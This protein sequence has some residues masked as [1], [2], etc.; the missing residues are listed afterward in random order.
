MARAHL[1]ARRTTISSTPLT[2]LSHGMRTGPPVWSTTTVFGLAVATAVDQ[3]VAVR[4]R[5]SSVRAG[6]RTRPRG[7]SRRRSPRRPPPP[8]LAACAEVAR[9]CCRSTVPPSCAARAVIAVQRRLRRARNR[10][11]GAVWPHTRPGADPVASACS[12]PSGRSRRS[13]CRLPISGRMPCVLEQHG[14]LLERSSR[15]TAL[16]A[17]VCD[18]SASRRRRQRRVEEPRARCARGPP[19]RRPRRSSPR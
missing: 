17:R 2:L 12:M 13:S 9:R 7:S 11:S 4:R 1:L 15:A 10:R 6:R 8:S 14:A 5:G 18:D 3:R 16:M 19:G